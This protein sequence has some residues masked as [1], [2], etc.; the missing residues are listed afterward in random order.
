MQALAALAFGLGGVEP[1][2]MIVGA[3][4]AYVAEAKR[5]LFGRVGIDLLAG[6]TEIL[7]LADE[8]API[9]SSWRPTCSGRRSTA[10][11]RR[12]CS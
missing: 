10:P 11:P 9:R 8:T 5:Q 3:G 7:V 2:D 4:N 12:R 6:P 1:V